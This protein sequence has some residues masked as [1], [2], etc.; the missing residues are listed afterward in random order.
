MLKMG[1]E[2]RRG[3]DERCSGKGEEEITSASSS[4]VAY[5]GFFRRLLAYFIDVFVL[6]VPMAAFVLVT[7]VR[8]EE[9]G[10]D[11]GLAE[12][13]PGYVTM[14][15]AQFLGVVFVWL[16]FA[17]LESSSLQATPGKLALGLRVTDENGD[18]ISFLRATGRHFAKA[19]SALILSIG[20]IMIAFTR[21]KQGLHDILARCLVVRHA[22]R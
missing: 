18:R 20:F 3:Y 15:G 12:T 17:V 14:H 5:G 8:P 13:P 4:S 6:F 21:R 16:Y 10:M 22:P 7:G 1:T 19:L 9:G 2:L 11:F